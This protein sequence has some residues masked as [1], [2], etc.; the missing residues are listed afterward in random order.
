MSTASRKSVI[1]G[2]V[3]R[4]RLVKIGALNQWQVE[5]NGEVEFDEQVG[6]VPNVVFPC[7]ALADAELDRPS[8][9][10]GAADTVVCLAHGRLSDVLDL[11]TAKNP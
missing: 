10:Y 3:G 7:A 6:D 5:L 9:Y 8:V 2:I 4:L 1:E 11:V